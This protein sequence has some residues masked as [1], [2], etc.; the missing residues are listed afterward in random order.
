[1]LSKPGWRLSSSKSWL[2]DDKYFSFVF[3]KSK[4]Q[5]FSLM[6]K[7]YFAIFLNQQYPLFHSFCT[8][9]W[10][11]QLTLSC[12]FQQWVLFFSISTEVTFYALC[13]FHLTTISSLL[14]RAVMVI[15]EH[16]DKRTTM[17]VVE[18]KLCHSLVIHISDL[19]SLFAKQMMLLNGILQYKQ[20]P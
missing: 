20:C 18:I 17:I 15:P 13:S 10:V 14:W 6:L 12:L 4:V 2:L 19:T 1:M 16:F 5:C 7:T 9:F 3:N 8:A 11:I